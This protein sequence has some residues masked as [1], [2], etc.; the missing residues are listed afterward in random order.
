[1]KSTGITRNIDRLGRIVIPMEL[2]RILDI[3]EKDPI[4]IFTE[5]DKIILRKYQSQ[6]ACMITG[7]VSER[8]FTLFNG[9]IVLSRKG[10]EFLIREL[11]HYHV[12]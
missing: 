3:A 1:M 10:A 6:H 7:D 9:N 11:Q 12:K 2:R 5:K 8:N 4:E